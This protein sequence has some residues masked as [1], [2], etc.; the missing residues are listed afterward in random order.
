MNIEDSKLGKEI[1]LC[2]KKS[3]Y[4]IIQSSSLPF[5]L[6]LFQKQ[7][8][9]FKLVESL[10]PK[11]KCKFFFKTLLLKIFVVFIINNTSQKDYFQK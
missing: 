11:E 10:K 4:F 8:I 3:I 5:N 7:L 1:Q 2:R 6:S 9:S